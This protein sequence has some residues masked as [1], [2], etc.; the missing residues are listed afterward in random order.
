MKRR[1]ARLSAA[2]SA[3]ARE[4]AARAAAEATDDADVYA[5]YQ[6]DKASLS[7][8]IDLLQREKA[9]IEGEL[10]ASRARA[11][12]LTGVVTEVVGGEIAQLEGDEVFGQRLRV[13]RLTEKRHQL[14]QQNLRKKMMRKKG[15]IKNLNQKKNNKLKNFL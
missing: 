13:L 11:T 9:S 10:E 12:T 1:K 3:P 4:R 6:S 7:R 2:L 14:M 8:A 15:M 5:A